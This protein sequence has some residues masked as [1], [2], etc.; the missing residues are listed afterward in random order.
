MAK[1]RKKR[2]IIIGN[3]AAGL[4]A[5]E[6]FRKR[7]RDSNVLM[8]DK[9]PFLAYSRMI[10]PYF[11]LGKVKKEED[12]FLRTKDFYREM[13]VKTLIGREVLSIDTQSREIILDNGKKEPFDFLLIAAGGSPNKPKVKGFDSKDIFVLR[14]LVDAR[15]LKE[16]KPKIRK[17]VFLGGGLVSIQTLQALFS[18]KGRYTLILKS[19]QVLS[20]TLDREASEIVERHLVRT[21]VQVIKGKDVFQVKEKDGSKIAIL[22][23]Q[24][25]IEADMIFAGKGVRPNIDFLEGSGIKTRNGIVVNDQMQTN[26]EGVYAAGDIAQARDFFSGEQVT[27][28][29]WPSAVEQGQ[30]AGK[31]M[32]GLKEIYPGN[33]KMNVT[34][35]F[36]MP[37]FSIGDIGPKRVAEALVK[38]DEKRDIYRKIC[39]DK[40]GII[41]GAVLINQID[42][43]GIL[44]GLIQLRKDV[45]VFRSR[46]QWKSPMNYASFYKNIL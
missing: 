5:L 26:I 35:I 41:V 44:H 12:L 37:I 25:E 22:D 3:S 31:N 38:K 29:L 13:G 1:A 8:I 32:A 6:A 7:D 28:G 19:D 16:I 17:A 2:I 11:I 42:D 9:E 36:A 18:M 15:K 21:G 24:S 39:L 45:G 40:K 14:S 20:Q 4:S 10:T 27:Y 43:L 34:R 46:S 30:T 33:L 23:D